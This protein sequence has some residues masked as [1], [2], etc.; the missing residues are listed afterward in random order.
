MLRMGSIGSQ[1]A[2]MDLSKIRIHAEPGRHE[3]LVLALRAVSQAAG[4]EAD[5]DALCAAMGVPFA[6]VSV[7]AEKAPGWW[8]MY[9][10]DAFVEPAADLFG[11]R[12][13]N[14]QPPDVGVEMT[15]AVEFPQHFEA[16][17]KPLIERALENGQ[18]VIAWEGW[19][20][21]SALCWGVITSADNDALSGV[22]MWAH[23]Q[24]VRMVAP[25]LQCYVVEEC[26]PR[27]PP[28]DQL[29]AMAMRHAD[30][31]MN[32]APFTATGAGAGVPAMTTGPAAFDAW[33]TWLAETEFG[34]PDQ[35][36]S[37]REH[38]QHAEFLV[39][40]GRSAVAFLNTIR[41]IVPQDRQDAMGE[42]IAT[43]RKRIELL[44]PSADE[45]AVRKAFASA[46]GRQ[47]LLASVHAAEAA[48]RR[49]G[50]MVEEFA[51]E[52]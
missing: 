32:R 2:G 41:E 38:R 42:I 33:E 16:S 17:Y 39:A 8:M 26:T 11:I 10:R 46:D 28:R 34:P 9:G 1:M 45:A 15:Q 19:P 36:K 3:S 21:M 47:Q 6:A 27:L 50:M 30:A 35:D 31:Y 4:G 7:R 48:D 12:L 52:V 22:T 20:D 43:C 51:R 29:L 14:L 37:W 23:E 5:Y 13:R 24:T 25:A 40:G 49:L 18:P 44:T